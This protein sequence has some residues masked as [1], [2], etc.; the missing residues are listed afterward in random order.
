MSDV[1]IIKAGDPVPLLF[2]KPA[3]VRPGTGGAVIRMWDGREVCISGPSLQHALRRRRIR[4]PY[5]QGDP[6]FNGATIQIEPDVLNQWLARGAE[7]LGP[8]A[9]LVAPEAKPD[10]FQS[11]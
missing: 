5:I 8:L 10:T 4:K 9:V 2:E 6:V 7:D 3:L 11:Q 1:V